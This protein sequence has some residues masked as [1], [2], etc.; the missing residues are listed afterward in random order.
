M[1]DFST[2]KITIK[3][4]VILSM[5]IFLLTGCIAALPV[6]TAGLIVGETALLA[7]DFNEAMKSVDLR[8]TVDVASAKVWEAALAT[9]EEME[10]EIIEKAFD[11]E[12]GNGIIKGKTNKHQNI[13]IIM[14]AATPSI[15]SIG[16]KARVREMM[17]MP[18]SSADVDVTFAQVIIEK[19]AE[20]LEKITG[21][22]QEIRLM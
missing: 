10:I 9:T 14:V 3:V 11:Q 18:I 7:M 8:S 20:H 16:V 1:R 17:N 13:Q 15:T 2:K 6:L 21:E 12:K 5:G 22:K 19:I 4:V